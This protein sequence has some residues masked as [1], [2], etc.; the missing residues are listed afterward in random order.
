MYICRYVCMYI[1]AD[2]LNNFYDKIFVKGLFSIGFWGKA[3]S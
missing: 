2:W 1:E 3:P